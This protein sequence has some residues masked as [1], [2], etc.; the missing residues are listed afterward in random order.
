MENEELHG[1]KKLSYLNRCSIVSFEA[2]EKNSSNK[3][4]KTV[5]L[6]PIS[7]EEGNTQHSLKQGLVEAYKELLLFSRAGEKVCIGLLSLCRR[8]TYENN[9][10]DSHARSSFKEMEELASDLNK[11]LPDCFTTHHDIEVE[12][13]LT[14]S[15]IICAYRGGYGRLVYRTLIFAGAESFEIASPSLVAHAYVGGTKNVNNL[16]MRIKYAVAKYG[17][18]YKG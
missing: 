6:Y 10:Y 7:P 12:S 2:K 17:A 15:D 11:E 1:G 14:S 4:L 8:H 18:M 5:L 3:Y 13:A 9:E 16:L